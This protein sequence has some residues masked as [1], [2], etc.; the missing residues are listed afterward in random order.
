M[1]VILTVMSLALVEKLADLFLLAT[2]DGNTATTG[3]LQDTAEGVERTE[4]RDDVLRNPVH[5]YDNVGGV[6]FDD[7]RLEPTN[8]T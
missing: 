5:L 7:A 8:G 6:H 2:G 1:T 4:K 3:I